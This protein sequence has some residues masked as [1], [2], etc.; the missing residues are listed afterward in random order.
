MKTDLNARTLKVNVRDQ[1]SF[2]FKAKGRIIPLCNLIFMFLN[3][4]Q[5]DKRFFIT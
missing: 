5:V 4:T 2:P 1:V 3:G